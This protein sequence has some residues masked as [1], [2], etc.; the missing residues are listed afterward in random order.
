MKE[1]TTFPTDKEATL[2]NSESTP[3]LRTSILTLRGSNAVKIGSKDFDRKEMHIQEIMRIYNSLQT[4]AKGHSES[5]KQSKA[6]IKGNFAIKR[7]IVRQKT[8]NKSSR[9]SGTLSKRKSKEL[10]V[11]FSLVSKSNTLSLEEFEYDPF[12]TRDTS[13]SRRLFP[14]AGAVDRLS[15]SPIPG[16]APPKVAQLPTAKP[17]PLRVKFD[18]SAF[19]STRRGSN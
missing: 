19:P 14:Q 3:L 1:G 4:N 10:L 16:T 15:L 11:F 9:R 8:A 17:T 2:N 13:H 5:S 18:A 6:K 12:L 7:T